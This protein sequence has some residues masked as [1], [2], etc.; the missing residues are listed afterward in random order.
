MMLVVALVSRFLPPIVSHFPMPRPSISSPRSTT[1][2][3]DARVE[4]LLN[5]MQSQQFV[6][7]SHA[8]RA[9]HVEQTHT[10]KM[11]NF[12]SF[13]EHDLGTRPTTT[14]LPTT[15][16]KEKE[17]HFGHALRGSNRARLQRLQQRNTF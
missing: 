11:V 7:C 8:A 2:S 15:T 10:K 9:H 14:T 4:D 3:H 6:F 17:T 16:E 5:F 12:S 1:H 13:R